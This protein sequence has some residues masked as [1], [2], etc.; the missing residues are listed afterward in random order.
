MMV[1]A[2]TASAGKGKKMNE[3]IE[4]LRGMADMLGGPQNAG[5]LVV[6]SIVRKFR[7]AADTLERLEAENATLREQLAEKDRQIKQ[8]EN[9]L[10]AFDDGIEPTQDVLNLLSDTDELKKWIAR[11][12]WHCRKVLEMNGEI[13]RL[14]AA[15]ERR[16]NMLADQAKALSDLQGRFN[17]I[18]NFE[19][20]QCAALLLKISERDKALARVT[21]ER[22]SLRSQQEQPNEP[23]T[24]DELRKIETVTPVWATGDFQAHWELAEWI[25]TKDDSRKLHWISLCGG[26]DY[27]PEKI[28]NKIYGTETMKYY[29]RKP[30]QEE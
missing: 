27:I 13:E 1:I 25:S 30:R 28:V 2:I 18:N 3:L 22:D 24:L 7:E 14:N 10:S 15:V 19:Q 21:A 17:I 11:A 20:S 6:P 23:L 12:A 16:D 9:A 29:R 26:E 8:W 4:I 5:N